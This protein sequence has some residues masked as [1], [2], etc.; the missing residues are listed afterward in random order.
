MFMEGSIDMN[1]LSRAVHIMLCRHDIFRSRFEHT[2]AG[3]VQVV[4]STPS[5][6]D[7]LQVEP[8]VDR[9]AALESLRQLE[10]HKYDISVEDTMKLVAFSWSPSH[11]ILVLGYSRF[12]GDGQTTENL[13]NE[14]GQLYAGVTLPPPVQ[15]CPEFVTRQRQDYESDIDCWV[16]L[17][18]KTAAELFVLDLP[19]DQPRGSVTGGMR[20]QHTV[21]V[22]L[23]PMIAI[24]EKE[25]SRK[26]KASP[27]HLYL[28]AFHVLLARLAGTADVAVGVADTNRPSLQNVA[29]M[30]YLA[31]LLPL[32]MAYLAA[33]TFGDELVATKEHMRT[34]LQHSQVPYNIL[35]DRLGI[36]P[37]RPG[38]DAAAPLFQAVAAR[39]RTPYDSVL[40]ISDDPTKTP[41]ITFKLLSAMYSHLGA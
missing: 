31:N 14:I 5:P 35:L 10:H 12:V 1:R 4:M 34:A 25:R 23:S 9:A 38:V 40:E 13:F 21:S 29:T 8:V 33:D 7:R 17:H 28:T 3:A 37:P 27:L 36:A 24:R 19:N 18:K 16:S 22:R 6:Q 2:E 30:G 11:H 39:E 15:Q 41:L 26:H 20:E 32:R